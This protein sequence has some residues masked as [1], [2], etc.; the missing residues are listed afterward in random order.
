MDVG[1]ITLPT[2][3]THDVTI[4][5]LSQTEAHI[6]GAYQSWLG[7][8]HLDRQVWCKTCGRD[9]EMQIAIEPNRIGL[10]CGHRILMYEG[11]VPV[12]ETMPLP[13]VDIV[14]V[15][16]V[17]PEQPIDPVDAFLLRQWDRFC[18][19][20]GLQ[21]ALFCQVCEAEGQSPGIRPDVS[22]T[23]YTLECRCAK[24]VHTGLAI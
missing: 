18:E 7:R 19:T 20:H 15:R 12:V 5:T 14:P 8:A 9:E 17:V 22:G 16:I 24:R 13:S 1:T 23:H 4:T 6:V 3:E 11:P 2:G 10:I 21:E